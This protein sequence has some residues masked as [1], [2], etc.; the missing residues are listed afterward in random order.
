M[1]A[2][3]AKILSCKGMDAYLGISCG[4]VMHIKRCGRT[5]TQATLTESKRSKHRDPPI[6]CPYILGTSTYVRMVPL[7]AKKLSCKEA[8]FISFNISPLPCLPTWTLCDQLTFEPSPVAA[9]LLWPPER[10]HLSIT[11]SLHISSCPSRHFSGS[12][13]HL[14]QTRHS[15]RTTARPN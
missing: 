9:S 8:G 4:N 11:F 12:S 2:V 15:T 6:P 14:F 13:E 3:K 10:F 5:L 1:V 7:K